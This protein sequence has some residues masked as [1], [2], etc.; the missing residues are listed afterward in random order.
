[1][2]LE[3]DQSDDGGDLCGNGG[4]EVATSGAHGGAD[5]D[6]P[7]SWTRPLRGVAFG[8]DLRTGKSSGEQ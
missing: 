5:G 3:V 7:A 1:V 2:S 8:G 6:S 4:S